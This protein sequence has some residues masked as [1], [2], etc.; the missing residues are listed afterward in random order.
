MLW[1]FWWSHSN[2]SSIRRRHSAEI[3]A[4]VFTAVVSTNE[5]YFGGRSITWEDWA[6]PPQNRASPLSPALWNTLHAPNCIN[7]ASVSLSTPHGS[8]CRAD[9]NQTMGLSLR[10]GS[11]AYLCHDVWS[12]GNMDSVDFYLE[13]HVPRQ[14]F[15]FIMC[16]LDRWYRKLRTSQEF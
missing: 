5:K 7:T 1:A 8:G 4:E 13:P 16:L 6:A 15:S 3:P 9:W 2:N 12:P 10:S 14:H 11:S